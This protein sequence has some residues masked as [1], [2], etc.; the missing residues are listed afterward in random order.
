MCEKR[1]M[2]ALS[3]YH[4]LGRSR[5]PSN[6]SYDSPVPRSPPRRWPQKSGVNFSGRRPATLASQERRRDW[7]FLCFGGPG[8]YGRRSLRF[9]RPAVFISRPAP[10][11][12]FAGR[13]CLKWHRLWSVTAQKNHQLRSMPLCIPAGRNSGRVFTHRTV[14]RLEAVV[15]RTKVPILNELK[16]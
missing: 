11:K 14:Q 7:F 9:L 3:F 16:S 15:R 1:R 2:T 6:A 5:A 13:H 8:Y 4:E 12:S 10:Q